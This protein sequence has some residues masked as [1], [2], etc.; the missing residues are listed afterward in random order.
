MLK[1][2]DLGAADL[3]KI[4]DLLTGKVIYC[5]AEQDIVEALRLGAY[6]EWTVSGTGVR[7]IGAAHGEKIHRKFTFNRGTGAGIEVYRNCG[8]YITISG[9]QITDY[10]PEFDILEGPLNPAELDHLPTCDEFFE[11]IDRPYDQASEQSTGPEMSGPDSADPS[12]PAPDGSEA[13]RGNT[14]DFNTASVQ[15]DYQKLIEE[16]APEGERSEGFQQVVW[17]LAGQG[18]SIEEIIEELSKHPNGISAKYA[19]RLAAEVQRSYDK[20]STQ[21]RARVSGSTSAAPSTNTPWPQIEVRA[22]E[23]PRTVNEAEQALILLGRD[24][25]HRGGMLMRPVINDLKASGDRGTKG[26][27]L[28]LVTQAYLIDALT[29]AARFLRFDKRAKKLVPVDAPAKVADILLSRR[30]GWKLP[31]LSGIINAPILRADGSI[32]E[33]P[34][35]DPESHLLFMPDDQVFPPVPQ[36]PSKADAA[37]ALDQLRELVKTF[38]FLGVTD[39]AVALAGMLTALDRRSLKTAPLIAFTAPAAGTGKSL[40]VDLISVLATGRAMPVLSQGRNEEEFEK[41]LGASLLAGDACISIDNCEAPLSGALLCQALTQGEVNIRLLGHSRNVNTTMNAAIFATGNNLVISGDLTRRCLLA[42]LDAGVERPELRSFSIDVIE[43]AHSRRGELV[44]AGLTIMRAWHVARAVGESINAQP[45]G[46]FNDWS[47][48]VREPL[49]WLGEADPCETVGK[50]RESDPQRDGLATVLL[51]W[52]ENLGENSRHTVQG[53]IDYA[54][55]IPEFYTALLNVA[56]HKTG[57][58]VSNDRLGRWLNR[59]Q[60][61]IVNGL[62]LTRESTKHGGY[63]IWTLKS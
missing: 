47:Q 52:K 24:I 43:E 22:G 13:I 8:R 18:W 31:K 46:S 54:I 49:L 53:V 50:V 14:F 42:S 44:I 21:K 32:Y 35:Y 30:G 23:I 26:W 11:A 55:N 39:R 34:G 25:Y 19:N 36:M 4:R 38:P 33:T 5:W 51:Q 16:G 1:G 17:H 6:V 2:A 48:R 41:R 40:L 58:M 12:E 10:V 15:V 56:A 3:D 27:Q 63:P 59:I 61:K 29:C 57:S 20:W 37:A 7:I 62:C 45:Y 28:V 9:L 60:G